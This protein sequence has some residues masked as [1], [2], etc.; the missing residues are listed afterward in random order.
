MLDQCVAE[1]EHSLDKL[2]KRQSERTIKLIVHN[3]AH[4]VS[5]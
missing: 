3:I 4:F 5:T 1:A 2:F